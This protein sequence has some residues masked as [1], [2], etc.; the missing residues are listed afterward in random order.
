MDPA[1]K[2]WAR[3]TISKL[4]SFSFVLRYIYQNEI[5]SFLIDHEAKFPRKAKN[6]YLVQCRLSARRRHQPTIDGNFLAACVCS[7]FVNPSSFY[8]LRT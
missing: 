5:R 3:V 1:A 2:K 6:L 7:M 8:S 4:L